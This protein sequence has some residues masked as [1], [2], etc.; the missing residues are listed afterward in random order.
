M[1]LFMYNAYIIYAFINYSICWIKYSYLFHFIN[2]F[3]HYVLKYI[4]I[5]IFIIT[6]EYLI[7]SYVNFIFLFSFSCIN[8]MYT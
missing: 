4:Y 5:H 7:Y 3:T 8:N 6:F 2:F 1:H